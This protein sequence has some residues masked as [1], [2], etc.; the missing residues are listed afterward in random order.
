MDV[1]RNT[2]EGELRFGQHHLKFSAG[3]QQGDPLWSSLVVVE[4][5]DDIGPFSDS[6]L[7]M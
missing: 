5:L 2:P 4:L 3:V 1:G 6:S 7:Q